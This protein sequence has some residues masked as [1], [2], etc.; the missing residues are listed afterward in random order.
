MSQHRTEH[1]TQ[2]EWDLWPGL[3]FKH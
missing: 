2:R 3:T 1:L